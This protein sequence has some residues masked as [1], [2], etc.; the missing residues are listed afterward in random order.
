MFYW[1]VGRHYVVLTDQ[2]EDELLAQVETSAVKRAEYMFSASARR[3]LERQM[4][5]RLDRLARNEAE[6]H[7]RYVQ[8]IG[9]G[10]R[11]LPVLRVL[12]DGYARTTRRA[13]W[14]LLD[15][16]TTGDAMA[17]AV[18]LNPEPD[19]TFIPLLEPLRFQRFRRLRPIGVIG[20]A[21]KTLEKVM[22]T[23]EEFVAITSQLSI[24]FGREGI[25]LFARQDGMTT[26]E[27]WMTK[28]SRLISVMRA[29]LAP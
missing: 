24:R 2:E 29:L 5:K 10:A 15:D 1:Q 22:G 16:L 13:A 14:G 26:N 25:R 7:L 8:R 11:A 19:T 28:R 4:G 17:A 20:F 12:L 3:R 6:F 9:H 18:W 23:T 21:T 27:E